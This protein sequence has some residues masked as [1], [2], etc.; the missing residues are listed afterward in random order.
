MRVEGR[1]TVGGD[2]EGGKIAK[3]LVQGF[4][5]PASGVNT[6]PSSLFITHFHTSFSSSSS[7]SFFIIISPSFVLSGLVLGFY[8]K[9]LNLSPF[10]LKFHHISS[11]HSLFSS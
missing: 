1:P 4:P 2:G 8:H 10:T 3:S 9:F 7:S 5:P 6:A 11:S